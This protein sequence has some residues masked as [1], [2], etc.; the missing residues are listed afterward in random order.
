[1]A[2]SIYEWYTTI[3]NMCIKAEMFITNA[4][5]SFI[6]GLIYITGF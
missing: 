3:Y 5:F 2:K 6:N 1:M 4:L